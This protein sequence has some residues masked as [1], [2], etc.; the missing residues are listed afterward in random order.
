MND[1]QPFS[2]YLDPS[3]SERRY[4]LGAAGYPDA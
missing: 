2:S 4:L 3:I 1:D